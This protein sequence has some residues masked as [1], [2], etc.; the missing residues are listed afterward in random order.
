[1]LQQ[2]WLNLITVT[3]LV[4]GSVHS[5]ACNISVLD[6]EMQQCSPVNISE[7][8]ESRFRQQYEGICSQVECYLQCL[9]DAIAVDNCYTEV[10]HVQFMYNI[11]HSKVTLRATCDNLD[12]YI[13]GIENCTTMNYTCMQEKNITER[14]EQII[15]LLSTENAT[16][17]KETFCQ[18]NKDQSSCV[19][20]VHAQENDNCTQEM[21]TFLTN[22]LNA[23]FSYSECGFPDTNPLFKLYSGDLNCGVPSSSTQAQVPNRATTIS[24]Q[25]Y[26]ISI[27]KKFP[28][29]T[30]VS[31]T[32]VLFLVY[33]I[34]RMYSSLCCCD[35]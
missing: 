30:S 33:T 11:S 32:K 8:V 10:S 9:S 20:N 15:A 27:L 17:Y 5:Q 34:W 18:L 26:Q 13:G 23:T 31:T 19:G 6:A 35:D 4:I 28:L 21:I 22:L 3:F 1:M 29:L 12:L 2:S 7:E 14:M 25:L 24:L 16:A